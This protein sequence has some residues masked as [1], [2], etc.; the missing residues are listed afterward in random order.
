MSITGEPDGTPG[1]GPQKVGVAVADLMTGIYAVTGILAALRHAEATGQGQQI[2]L[3]LLD[4]QVGWLANQA[5]NYLIGGEIPRRQG[6]AHPNIV[7]YQV[8]PLWRDRGPQQPCPE[9]SP[10]QRLDIEDA[11]ERQ[12]EHED[13]RPNPVDAP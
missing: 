12:R 10:C 2:D 6:T 1:G 8:M 9:A 5:M 3:A 11:T 7:P 4:T 13:E